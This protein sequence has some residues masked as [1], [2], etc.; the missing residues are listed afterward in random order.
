MEQELRPGSAIPVN[1]AFDANGNVVSTTNR[2]NQTV[3]AQ[4]DALDR[5][6]SRTTPDGNNATFGYKS[7]G[8]TTEGYVAASNNESTDTTFVDAA[9]RVVRQATARHGD[10]YCPGSAGM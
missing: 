7:S 6:T 9:G 3:T 4:Y 2:L 10:W 8:P 5:Q 1:H